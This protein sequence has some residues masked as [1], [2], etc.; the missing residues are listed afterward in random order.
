MVMIVCVF[1]VCFLLFFVFV[2]C[3][4]ANLVYRLLGFLLKTT[5]LQF[6]PIAYLSLFDLIVLHCYLEFSHSIVI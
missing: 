4:Y 5:T 2:A 6:E 3:L 1:V